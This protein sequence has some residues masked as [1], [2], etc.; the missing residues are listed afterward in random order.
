MVFI[1]H[2]RI[3]NQNQNATNK[4]NAIYQLPNERVTEYSDRFF[5]VCTLTRASTTQPMV[6]NHFYNKLL[7]AIQ[8]RMRKA[9]YQQGPSSEEAEL[10]TGMYA[11]LEEAVAAAKWAEY[12]EL[13][14][15]T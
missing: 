6:I 5:S 2:F 7:P 13:D 8:S 9:H 15:I 11:T 1:N 3:T 4:F 10:G 14:K 12:Y